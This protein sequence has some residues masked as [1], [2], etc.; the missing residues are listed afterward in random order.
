[1]TRSLDPDWIYFLREF[2]LLYHSGSA[3]GSAPIRSHMRQVRARIARLLHHPTTFT[4][5]DPWT[6]PVVSHWAR[7]VDLALVER[8]ATLARVLDRLAPTF[9]WEYGYAKVPSNLR[10]SY[11]FT[12]LVG[13]RGPVQSQDLILGLVLF[14]PRCTYPQHRHGGIT[15]SYIVVSGHVSENDV[16][17]YAPSSLIYNPPGYGHRITT[18]ARTPCLLAYAWVGEPDHLAEPHMA[19][20]RSKRNAAPQHTG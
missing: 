14:A 17:V 2:E 5:R 8:T 4:P 19:F 1:M 12:E 11:G 13:P 15:E 10:Q 6:L 3:G 7:A 16:G 18:A 20:E 9:S